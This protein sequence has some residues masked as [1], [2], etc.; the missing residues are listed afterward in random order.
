SFEAKGVALAATNVFR[1]NE[2][3]HVALVAGEIA[4]K[5]YLNGVLV[6]TADVRGAFNGKREGIQNVL[7]N[8]SFF[9]KGSAM[10]G[11]IRQAR[12]WGIERTL[13]Q[14]REDM[15]VPLKGNVPGLV[16]AWNFDDPINLGKDI[17]GHGADATLTG[18]AALAAVT[19]PT[20]VFGQI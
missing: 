8:I 9:G 15:I 14:I 4:T 17:S 7:G 3:Y 13:A 20:R 2:W 10:V 12:V 19:E 6:G 5:F 16:A 11:F 18:Q 1:T